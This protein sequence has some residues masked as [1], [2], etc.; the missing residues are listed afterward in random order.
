M[1]GL[2]GL[3]AM[4][5][6]YNLP[7]GITFHADFAQKTLVPIYAA[8]SGTPTFTATRG[9]SNPATY[10]SGEKVVLTTTSNEPRFT[11]GFYDDEGFKNRPGVL[12][13]GASTNDLLHSYGDTQSG[14]KLTSWGAAT[15]GTI[16]GTPTYST[17]DA[18]DLIDITNAKAQRVQYTGVAG[19]GGTT[20]DRIQ[21][22]KQTTADGTFSQDD[23]ATISCW[24]KSRTGNSGVTVRLKIWQ[25]NSAGGW[26]T[27]DGINI[28]PD[29]IWR[30]YHFTYTMNQATVARANAVLEVGYVSEGDTVD[31]EATGIQ[32]ENLA[33]PSTFI[34]TTTAALTRN[35]EVLKYPISGNRTAATESTCIRLIPFRNDD[36]NLNNRIIDTES[37]RR[38]I[39]M[40]WRN[41]HQWHPN[42]TDSSDCSINDFHPIAYDNY[43][44]YTL[45]AYC[46]HSSPY[47][48]MYVDGIVSAQTE[49]ADDFTNPAW[50]T[51]FYVGSDT[52]G[53]TNNYAIFQ[54]IAIFN[55]VLDANEMMSV[56]Q[57]MAIDS[58]GANPLTYYVDATSGN[59]SD[60]GRTD[61]NAW[62]TVAKVNAASLP[63]GCTVLFKKGE[64]WREQLVPQSG[65]DGLPITYGAYGSGNKPKFLGSVTRSATGEW[66]DEGSNIWRTGDL[67]VTGSELLPNPSLDTNADDWYAYFFTGGG[68][69]GS[70]TRD[71]TTFD[72]TPASFRVDCTT[73]G[74]STS[75]IQVYTAPFSITS[76]TS[77]KMTFAA[78]STSAFTLHNINILKNSS[79]YTQY[80]DA[81]TKTNFDIT[82]S[83]QTFTV[84][85]RASSTATDARVD[86]YMG[87]LLPDGE[88]F[89][90]D[91]V[92]VKAVTETPLFYDVG[93]IIMDT[94]TAFGSK[95]WNE[96]DLNVQDEFWYDEDTW[97]LKMYSTQNPAT[98]H[99]GLELAL[100]QNGIQITSNDYIIL[101]DLDLRYWAAHAIQASTG[102][103][104]ITVKDCD[105]SYIGG[106]DQYG[107]A[108][109]VRY[110]NGIEWWQGCSDMLV[111]RCLISQCY[112]SGVTSQG[113]NDG[114]TAERQI[115]RNNVIKDCENAFEFWH[116][117]GATTV[118]DITFDNN[119]CIRGGGA[120]SHSQRPDVRGLAIDIHLNTATTTNVKFRNNILYEGTEGLVRWNN[121][122]DVND[123][124]LDYNCFYQSSGDIVIVRNGASYEM[125]D[126]ADYQNDESQDAN[127]VAT[128]PLMTDP[129][130]DDFSLQG[131]SP[132]LNAGT[133]V[134]TSTDLNGNI[135]DVVPDMGAYQ[136][137]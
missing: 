109:T 3:G 4:K 133:D 130:N 93:N 136:S 24:I 63:A 40:G 67:T 125:A 23:I 97:H 12:V 76:G 86:W 54:S 103:S 30:R 73:N 89:H 90:I 74:S 47:A 81:I 25:L 124:A 20:N 126:F 131:E 117:A 38:R 18:T 45:G 51:S 113:L 66:T 127:S 99:T 65:T 75:A 78:K 15:S 37:K 44:Q 129:D 69:A 80:Q 41:D 120:W 22:S 14:G 132:C 123:V 128:D 106:A 118:D 33:L 121:S 61:A 102:A 115:F 48:G 31:V 36:Y 10:L 91:T 105:I 98:E 52:S 49:T 94:E 11:S 114:Y 6:R 112:D 56:H 134:G 58:G 53:G 70:S 95:V 111:E 62:Q 50:G 100:K 21:I 42:Q 79:P 9:A 7:S 83:F 101:Q 82:T 60:D 68:A 55:R 119:T 85:F 137:S 43:R 39:N 87:G 77:Y 110:G 17:P 32:L 13:E 57:G 35:A 116:R 107:G 28:T 46:Q 34:P 1:T 122:D 2:I 27:E 104:N 96:G 64:T 71:T 29:S 59:D 92:S 26:L 84:Y 108:N 5:P 8:G 19:D 88:S 16:N 135:L 72:S